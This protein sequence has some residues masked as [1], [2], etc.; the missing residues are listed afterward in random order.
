MPGIKIIGGPGCGKTTELLTILKN[1]FKNGLKHDEVAMVA[2]ARATVFHLQKRAKDELN[3]SE[4]QQESIK[5]I[6]AYCMDKLKG[7]E[8]FA[9]NHKR[10]FKKK[11]KIDPQNW[12]KI[13][14]HFDDIEDKDEFAVWTEREDK[15]LGLI[16]QLIGLARHNMSEDIEGLINYYNI[17]QS[18]NFDK[19]REDE[20]RDINYLYTKFKK[21]HNLIDFEDMLHKALHKDIIFPYYEILMG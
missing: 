9:S 21:Q 4:S 16:L 10:E 5:T 3:Y 15:K 2:F 17:N 20:V 12:G 14:T 13:D 8:V 19:I 7:Y 11:I 18:H 6:H 1:E